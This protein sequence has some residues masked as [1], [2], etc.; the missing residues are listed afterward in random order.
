HKIQAGCIYLIASSG[1]TRGFREY[2]FSGF[3]LEALSGLGKLKSSEPSEMSC[4]DKLIYMENL[5]ESFSDVSIGIYSLQVFTKLGMLMRNVNMAQEGMATALFMEIAKKTSNG[6]IPLAEIDKLLSLEIV[7]L[8]KLDELINEYIEYAVVDMHVES[9]MPGGKKARRENRRLVDEITDEI[10]EAFSVMK[11]DVTDLH[12]LRE[13]A[14]GNKDTYLESDGDEAV[15]KLY[16]ALLERYVSAY[17]DMWFYEGKA[18]TRGLSLIFVTRIKEIFRTQRRQE[19]K[20]IRDEC[21]S[22]IEKN[23]LNF[24][25]YELEGVLNGLEFEK[26]DFDAQYAIDPAASKRTIDEIRDYLGANLE[27]ALRIKNEMKKN[28]LRI[29][30]PVNMNDSERGLLSDTVYYFDSII[31]FLSEDDR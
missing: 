13:T 23:L 26:D 11:R 16:I 24:R 6:G 1:V 10:H 12:I 5:F 21:I 17:E 27:T 14:A 7:S 20:Y 22:I 4:A 28:L 2:E 29:M 25:V 3:V 8:E 30:D 15:T 19:A 31:K 9:I 18:F